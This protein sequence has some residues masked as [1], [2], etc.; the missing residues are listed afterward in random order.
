MSLLKLLLNFL[1]TLTYFWFCILKCLVDSCRY[2]HI[3]RCFV[4]RSQLGSLSDAEELFCITYRML[5]EAGP[6]YA[7][8]KY[9]VITVLRIYSMHMKESINRGSFKYCSISLAIIVYKNQ[10][11]RGL[12][13]L[14]SKRAN[15]QLKESDADICTQPMDRSSWPLCW[16]REGWKKLRRK[17]TL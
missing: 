5:N 8:F 7:L 1:T 15:K 6:I 14:P 11:L 9:I 2:L 3:V 17:A 16:I 4:S 13:W 10:E 12:T